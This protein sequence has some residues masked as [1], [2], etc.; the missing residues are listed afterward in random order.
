MKKTLEQSV[1]EIFIDT[2][3]EII[4][5]VRF[6]EELHYNLYDKLPNEMLDDWTQSDI[7]EKILPKEIENIKKLLIKEK[8]RK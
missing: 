8:Y 2:I 5:N 1:K 3:L 6:K 4:N 7:Y